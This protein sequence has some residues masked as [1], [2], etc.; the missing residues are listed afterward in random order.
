MSMLRLVSLSARAVSRSDS[1]KT[2]ANGQRNAAA[3]SSAV[4]LPLGPLGPLPAL[5]KAALDKLTAACRR[6]HTTAAASVAAR[7]TPVVSPRPT[8]VMSRVATPRMTPVHSRRPSVCSRVG[9]ARGFR[10]LASRTGAAIVIAPFVPATFSRA[11]QSRSHEKVR[12]RE[13]ERPQQHQAPGSTANTPVTFTPQQQAGMQAQSQVFGQEESAASRV[14]KNAG[15]SDFLGR[16]YNTTGLSVVASLLGSWG[17]S[18]V[19]PPAMFM[20]ALVGGFV[21]SLGSMFAL[22]RAAPPTTQVPGQPGKLI[23]V[24][25]Q[26]RKLAYGTFVASM[27]ATL[28]PLVAVCNVVHPLIVPVS[29]V[30]AVAVMAGASYYAFKRPNG[31]LLYLTGPLVGVLGASILIQLG[32][33]A[34]LYFVGPNLFA[35]VAFTAYPYVGLGIFSVFTAVDTHTA[36]AEYEEGKADHLAHA[37]SFYLNFLNMFTSI[38]RILLSFL[39]DD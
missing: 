3:L 23:T 36:I 1:R 12:V 35:S 24:N 26:G 20:P 28:T 32:A 13:A 17:L 7:V 6:H 30:G 2:A 19:L 8:P 5:N 11:V 16:V 21:V 37:A 22:Y 34:S 18:L 27:A 25:S 39:R 33:L 4:S 10:S 15:L 14:V 31:S 38:A 29:A 9:V